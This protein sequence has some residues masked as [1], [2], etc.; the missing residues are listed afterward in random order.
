MESE[1][2]IRYKLRRTPSFTYIYVLAIL[3]RHVLTTCLYFSHTIYS[4]SPDVRILFISICMELK[5]TSGCTYKLV[6]ISS[7][8]WN[9]ECFQNFLYFGIFESILSEKI[10]T[11]YEN[12]NFHCHLFLCLKILNMAALLKY[13]VWNYEK[14]FNFSNFV[15]FV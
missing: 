7:N 9:F 14:N 6:Q 2:L 15:I 4:M 10:K 1:N 12:R 5:Q 8:V 3:R 11:K 13:Q